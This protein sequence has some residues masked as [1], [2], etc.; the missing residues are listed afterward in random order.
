MEPLAGPDV[1]LERLLGGDRDRLDFELERPR[2]DPARR[3][4]S[5]TLR[6]GGGPSSSSARAANAPIVA[7]PAAQAAPRPAGPTPGRG[8]SRTARGTPPR[9]RADDGARPACAGRSPPSRP[10]CRLATPSEHERPSARDCRCTASA[11][12]RAC[13]EV[14]GDLVDVE[15]ALVEAGALDRGADLADGSDASRVLGVDAVPRAD[16]DGLR[17]APQR[18]RAAHR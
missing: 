6:P 5:S 4:R 18:L 3:S 15:V 16:E 11:T 12:A 2:V 17:A 9:A 7:T 10:P 13:A 8:G 1:A 14:A